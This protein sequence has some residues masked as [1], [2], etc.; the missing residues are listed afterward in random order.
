M[1]PL[2]DGES[3][4]CGITGEEGKG[5]DEVD[6]AE[7]QTEDEDKTLRE[8][9]IALYNKGEADTILSLIS[10]FT[11]EEERPWDSLLLWVRPK[12]CCLAALAEHVRGAN[13]SAVASVG[14]GTG[15]LE[16][17][18]QAHTGLSVVGYEVNAEW[19][20][21]R[22]APPTFIPLTYVDTDA[23]PPRVPPTH[24][25]MC[26]YFNDGK[27]FRQYVSAY[28]GPALVIIGATSGERHTDPHPL[29]YVDEG[30][31]RLTFTHRI[32]PEDL[33]AGYLRQHS[34]PGE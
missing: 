27:A 22:Y 20:S 10:T 6:E 9:I 1:D 23:A 4:C 26:C 29:D 25:L 7:K 15:L 24:A 2:E 17:L 8:E 28:E 32:S 13:I 5:E 21:S 14:C 18:V 19:W 11:E 16:W 12:P 31:W 33:L 30:S 3:C 34:P